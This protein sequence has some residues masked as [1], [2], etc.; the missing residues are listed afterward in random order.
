[1]VRQERTNERSSVMKRVGCIVFS[2]LNASK[3]LITSV[4]TSDSKRFRGG[5]K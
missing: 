4:N 3:L 5:K 2:V 1:M